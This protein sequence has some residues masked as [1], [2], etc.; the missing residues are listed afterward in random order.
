LRE[1]CDATLLRIAQ[2]VIT[3]AMRGAGLAAIEVVLSYR[4]G[5]VVLEV[6]TSADFGIEGMRRQ[7]RDIGGEIT[8]VN[9]AGRGTRVIVTV[10]N[11]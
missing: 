9:D 8:I 3:N 7:A 1:P 10:P 5:S 11:A 6:S 2:E 4:T